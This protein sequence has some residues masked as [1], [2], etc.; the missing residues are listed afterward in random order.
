MVKKD[1]VYVRQS[2]WQSS[3]E[4]WK[5]IG[6]YIVAAFVVGFILALVVVPG[7]SGAKPANCHVTGKP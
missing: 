7:S 4:V 6:K 2:S 1:T 5:A 3:P